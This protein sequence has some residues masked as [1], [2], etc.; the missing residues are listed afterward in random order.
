[1][2]LEQITSSLALLESTLLSQDLLTSSPP[3]PS[4]LFISPSP[5][6]KQTEL[7]YLSL[8]NTFTSITSSPPSLLTLLTLQ[9][10][11]DDNA[12]HIASYPVLS[13]AISSA[14]S[15]ISSTLTSSLLPKTTSHLI[16]DLDFPYSPSSYSTLL[17]ALAQ[18]SQL[19]HTLTQA[20]FISLS[21]SPSPTP[22]TLH[23]VDAIVSPLIRRLNHHFPGTHITPSTADN[24]DSDSDDPA[25]HPDPHPNQTTDRPDRPEWYFKHLTSQLAA[26]L[27]FLDEHIQ[28]LLPPAIDARYYYL[29][30]V[31]SFT[32]RRLLLQ[33][34]S[35]LSVSTRMH[36]E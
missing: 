22:T 21:S 1:M 23:V 29:A 25:S 4:S 24:S 30:R 3:P 28:P 26:P 8:L 20:Q 16:L 6:T 33:L 15:S 7:L 14:F 19:L 11:H 10:F 27:A 31:I 34:P 2:S 12:T 5:S 35:I 18:P 32:R 13:S 17:P 9:S 36:L